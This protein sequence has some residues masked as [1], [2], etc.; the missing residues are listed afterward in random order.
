MIGVA[1][2]VPQGPRQ[3]PGS[4]GRLLER[5]RQASAQECAVKGVSK[6]A[7]FLKHR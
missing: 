4:V 3:I 7:E 5:R 2:S 1:P 6:D